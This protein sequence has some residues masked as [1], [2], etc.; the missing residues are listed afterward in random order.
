MLERP[1]DFQQNRG[2]WIESFQL[3]IERSSLPPTPKME[4][5]KT[6]VTPIT[7]IQIRSPAPQLLESF[8][9]LPQCL[10]F[11]PADT[12]VLILLGNDPVQ[13]FLFAIQRGLVQSLNP[14]GLYTL[15][16]QS[17]MVCAVSCKYQVGSPK[18]GRSFT[19]LR[20]NLFT[21]KYILFSE[22]AK[23]RAIMPLELHL[24]L[25]YK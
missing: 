10:Y 20:T 4:D 5:I 24:H 12:P 9:F 23:A 21:L 18:E 22:S 13:P 3:D 11:I 25:Q 1:L 15:T 6:Q 17:Q 7:V 19:S 16:S 8:F 2:I 14:S